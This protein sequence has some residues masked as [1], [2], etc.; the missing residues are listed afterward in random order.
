MNLTSC[1]LHKGR[2]RRLLPCCAG[3]M[4]HTLLW[5]GRDHKLCTEQYMLHPH[6][7]CRLGAKTSEYHCGSATCKGQIVNCDSSQA[8][9]EASSR[10]A[11]NCGR[12]KGL[13]AWLEA[14][15]L[16]PLFS[17]VCIGKQCVL[18]MRSSPCLLYRR[19]E[20]PVWAESGECEANPGYMVGNKNRPGDCLVSCARCDLLPAPGAAARRLKAGLRAGD[21][22]TA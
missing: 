9:C 6:H 18:T 5:M 21:S 8:C 2:V 14:R 4:L 10:A 1:N 12:T 22:S 20:C 17:R 15:W 16:W 19:S 11:C 7:Q 3:Y 13:C